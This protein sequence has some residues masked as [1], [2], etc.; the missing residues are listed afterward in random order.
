MTSP[1][2]AKSKWTRC[3]SAESRA[4][5]TARDAPLLAGTPRPTTGIARRSC[6]P[7]SSGAGV[8]VATLCR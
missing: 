4:R 8:S 2:P 1:C 7:L 3:S 6:S 5:P